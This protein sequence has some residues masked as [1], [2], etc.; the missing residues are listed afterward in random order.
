MP[1]LSAAGLG[2]MGLAE[3]DG[4]GGGGGGRDSGLGVGCK[5]VTAKKRMKPRCTRDGDSLQLELSEEH[6]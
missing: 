6:A 3:P 2:S 4:A 1:L 5:S